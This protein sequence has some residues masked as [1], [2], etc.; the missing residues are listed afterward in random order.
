MLPSSE[1]NANDLQIAFQYSFKMPGESKEHHAMWDY[2]IGLVRMT[3]W[4][5]C[6]K[7]PKVSEA[8]KLIG[9]YLHLKDYSSQSA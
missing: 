3:A 1:V 7:Y 5:K 4:F 8:N 2:N 6:L 9:Q